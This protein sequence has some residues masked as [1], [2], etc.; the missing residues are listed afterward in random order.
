MVYG[1]SEKKGSVYPALSPNSLGRLLVSGLR[2][3]TA[4][5]AVG[6][7]QCG[8]LEVT[9][10]SYEWQYATDLSVTAFPH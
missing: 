4:A 5:Y 2:F 6:P 7:S 10:S 9:F 8:I 3:L 1:P